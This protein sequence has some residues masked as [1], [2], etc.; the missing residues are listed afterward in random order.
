MKGMWG[1][2]ITA[3][4]IGAI[5]LPMIWYGGELAIL[6]SFDQVHLPEWSAAVEQRA[7]ESRH[8]REKLAITPRPGQRRMTN[9]IVEVEA[10]IR[11][12]TAAVAATP[13]TTPH[14]ATGR[15]V[16]SWTAVANGPSHASAQCPIVEG[17]FSE[18]V[19]DPLTFFS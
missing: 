18:D 19:H 9:V 5:G 16:R 11:S 6:E 1:L 4:L 3:L 12:R 2:R 10:L 14:P 13:Q 17:Q 15:P 7:V 8:Q